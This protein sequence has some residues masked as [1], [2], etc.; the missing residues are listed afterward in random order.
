MT[1]DKNQSHFYKTSRS[2]L[3]LLSEWFF[4]GTPESGGI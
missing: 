2:P 3:N 4:S 1:Q